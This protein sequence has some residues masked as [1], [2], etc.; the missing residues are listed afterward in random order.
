MNNYA[1]ALQNKTLR[2]PFTAFLNK[3]AEAKQNDKQLL[4][5]YFSETAQNEFFKCQASTHSSR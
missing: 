5:L 4:F 2:Q 3:V 1:K